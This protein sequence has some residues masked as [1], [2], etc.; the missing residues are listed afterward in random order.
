MGV[1]FFSQAV[2][3]KEAE[4]EAAYVLNAIKGYDVTF[5]VVFDWEVISSK[6]DA[7]TGRSGRDADRNGKGV[8]AR[9]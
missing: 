2:N 8:S 1:Y 7:D 6:G 4:E 3:V 5:P 9:R